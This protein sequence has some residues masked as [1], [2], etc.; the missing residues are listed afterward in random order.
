MTLEQRDLSSLLETA[1]VAARLAG[2]KALE[3]INYVKSSVKDGNEIVTES[4]AR[5]Q[6]LIID[7]IKETYP[8]HGFIGEEGTGGKMFKQAPRGDE[9]IWWVI[10]P[11]DGTNNYSHQMPIFT[12]SI[13]AMHEGRPIVG[14]VFD[15]ATERIYTAVEGGEAQLNGRRITVSEDKMNMFTSVALNSSF[16]DSVPQWAQQIMLK[17]RFRNL[18]SLALE[19]AYLACGCLVGVAAGTIKLWDIAA[20]VLIVESAGGVVT[21]YKGNKLFPM[22]AETYDGSRFEILAANKKAHAELLTLLQK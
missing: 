17:T 7:R 6:K 20:G 18:G 11:I 21:D 12:V 16:T 13:A 3:D 15:P 10:D 2:Q 8:D 9:Q 19:L 4:D 1:I 5:C 14:V 22:D